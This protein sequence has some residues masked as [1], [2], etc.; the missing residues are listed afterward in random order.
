MKSIVVLGL[1]ISN[2]AFAVNPMGGFFLD[3][4][5]GEK[6]VLTCLNGE[7]A[8]ECE[9]ANFIALEDDREAVLHFN[10][11]VP[12]DESR[13]SHYMRFHMFYSLRDTLVMERSF[14]PQPWVIWNAMR[15]NNAFGK[16]VKVMFSK[17]S[18]DYNTAIK[19]S[20]GNFKK[21]KEIIQG[22]L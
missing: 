11:L 18:A 7:V 16:A 8:S 1:L 15:I 17:N 10:K 13:D 2:I 19:L 22:V 14:G 20:H 12:M 5:T 3:K 4:K 21:L 9:Q 6:I